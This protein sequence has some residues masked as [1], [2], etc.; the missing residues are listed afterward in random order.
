MPKN[1]LT[2]I[3]A[4][5]PAGAHVLVSTDD[6]L[7][8][9]VTLSPVDAE[10][11]VELERGRTNSAFVYLDDMREGCWEWACM[12]ALLG[13]LVR[14][15]LLKMELGKRIGHPHS[16]NTVICRPMGATA[17]F[18]VQVTLELV[19]TNDWKLQ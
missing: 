16:Q 17:W 10:G 12:Q 9:A 11:Y 19:L 2:R 18:P 6:Q 15:D 1:H 3:A 4:N 13:H 5:T 7:I 8:R 14:S